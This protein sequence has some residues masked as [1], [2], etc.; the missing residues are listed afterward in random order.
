MN[1]VIMM[2][3]LTKDPEIR[4]KDDKAVARYSIAVDRKFKKDEADFFTCVSFGKQAEFVEK[5]LKKGMKI[6][7]T[8]RLQNNEFTNKDGQKVRTTEILVE[9]VEFAESRK[10]APKPSGDDFMDIPEGIDDTLPF[11]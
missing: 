11:K 4:Y 1:K 2:G 3:R 6:A 7:L 9:D 8:G 10:D 5:Y